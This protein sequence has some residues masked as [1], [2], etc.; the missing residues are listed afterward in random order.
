MECFQRSGAAQALAPAIRAVPVPRGARIVHTLRV[1]ADAPLLGGEH[2]VD[3]TTRRAR[4]RG[5][6]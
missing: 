6:T 2:A 4:T 3:V 1:L 5:P